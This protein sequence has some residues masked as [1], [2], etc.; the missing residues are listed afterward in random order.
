M[1]VDEILQRKGRDVITIASDS[2]IEQVARRLT[3]HRIGALVVFAAGTADRMVG[4]ITERDIVR[5]VAERGAAALALPAAAVM[6]GRVMTCSPSDPID[7]LMALITRERI[8]HVPVFE[9]EKLAG[10]VSIG[11]VVKHQLD[12]QAAE[13]GMWRELFTPR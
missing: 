9:H 4:I 8:R 3:D 5:L 11:D 1:T 13:I 10:I 6:T 2:T 12:E 7:G